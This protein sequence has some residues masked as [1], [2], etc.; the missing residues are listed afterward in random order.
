MATAYG[1][2]SRETG[3]IYISSDCPPD[4]KESI[5]LEEIGHHIDALFNEQETPGDEGTLF[6]ATVRGITLSDEEIDVTSVI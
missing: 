4:L 2:Y 1:A 3:S 6:S 5:L